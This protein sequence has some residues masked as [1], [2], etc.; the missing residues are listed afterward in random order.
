MLL[1]FNK[2]SIPALTAPIYQSLSSAPVIC[3]PGS[4]RAGDSGDSAGL[5][6]VSARF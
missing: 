3:I 6:T 5:T 2:C 4:P 1:S